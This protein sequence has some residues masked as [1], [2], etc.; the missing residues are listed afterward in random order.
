[1]NK[2][3]QVTLK[4]A[5]AFNRVRGKF[6]DSNARVFLLKRGFQTERFEVVGAE[7]TQD[8]WIEFDEYRGQMVLMYATLDAGF[9]DLIA[10]TSYVAYGAADSTGQMEVYSIDPDRRDVVPPNGDSLFWKVFITKVPNERFPVPVII[11]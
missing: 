11:P 5:N 2:G 9:N 10:Q 4:A 3:Q 1:M 7:L 8:W 6:F